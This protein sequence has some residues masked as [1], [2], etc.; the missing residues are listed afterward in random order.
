MLSAPSRVRIQLLTM[1]W[2]VFA[3]MTMN[4]AVCSHSLAGS[5]DKT[6]IF[7]DTPK[8][9]FRIKIKIKSLEITFQAL[10]RLTG[11]SSF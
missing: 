2:A 8:Q 1:P 10:D 4:D 3:G 9:C 5:G 6:F 7:F 11:R